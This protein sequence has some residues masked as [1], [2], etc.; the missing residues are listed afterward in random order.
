MKR[1]RL[2]T[3]DECKA[4]VDALNKEEWH[5][6]LASTKAATGTVKQN[7]EIRADQS[8]IAKGILV[9]IRRRM[10]D[11]PLAEESIVRDIT[12]PKFNKY[13][14]GGN[15][16]NHA[17][18]GLMGNAIRTDLACTLFLNDD[19]E[20]GELIIHGEPSFSFKEK[21]GYCLVYDCWR[22][23]EVRPVTEGERICAITWLQ[24]WIREPEKREVIRMFRKELSAIDR[25]SDE[26]RLYPGLS[27]I[28]GKLMRFWVD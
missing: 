19:Y 3:E 25:S 6:G 17:D 23:H 20:G 13:A 16:G 10:A 7:L 15:Y 28:Y 27:S 5:Q 11:S 9:D 14:N 26:K 8:E 4:I 21:P 18:A 24:S 1:Y 12:I 22:P 2:F